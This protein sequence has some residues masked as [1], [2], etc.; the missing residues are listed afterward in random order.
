MVD[1]NTGVGECGW[2]PGVGAGGGGS[3]ADA[4]DGM[5]FHKHTSDRKQLF[6]WIS[7]LE[8]GT[9]GASSH[10]HRCVFWL[11]MRVWCQTGHLRNC[12]VWRSCLN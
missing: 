1:L 4:W 3:A 12:A 2:G 6:L 9:R 8:W 7:V 5:L 10:S 11:K